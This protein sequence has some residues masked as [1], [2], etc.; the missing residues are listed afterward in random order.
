MPFTPAWTLYPP[1]CSG[2]MEN[3][4]PRPNLPSRCPSACHPVPVY[5]FTCT[6]GTVGAGLCALAPHLSPG[7]TH[8]SSPQAPCRTGINW[9]V[10]GMTLDILSQENSHSAEQF[11]REFQGLACSGGLWLL[12]GSSSPKVG[13]FR[14][15]VA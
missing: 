7:I 8:I 4:A 15:S 9:N 12:E 3:E 11:L 5:K 1:L 14:T 6:P 2:S 10:G 13:F